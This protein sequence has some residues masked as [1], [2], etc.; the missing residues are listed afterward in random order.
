MPR[1]PV[2]TL[3]AGLLAFAPATADD[4]AKANPRP[5]EM[6]ELAAAIT[7]TRPGA[8]GPDALLPEPLYRYDDPTRGFSDGS[9]WAF[10]PAGRPTALFS[11]SLQPTDRGDGLRWIH[12][13]TALADGPVAAS[14]RHASG[15]WLWNPRGSG[16]AFRPI[17]NTPAPA[18]DA[19]RRLR[20]ARDAARRFRATES[21]DPA[22]DDP[23][24]RFDLR[25]LPQPVHRYGDPGSGLVDGFLFLMVHGQNPEAVLVIE[26][27]GSPAAPAWRYAVA[28]VSAAQ[29]RVAIDGA[30]VADLPKPA[31]AGWTSPYFLFERPARPATIPT[32]NP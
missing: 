32:P 6:R 11:V 14:S 25:L 20:Q 30:E 29:I 5:A 7:L 21:L 8:G 31:V 4:G 24:D 3:L 15:G 9:L 28:R 19:A 17:P 22:R 27:A 16:L 2:G 10:G 12:E 13:M 23:A 26:A 18:D 1:R